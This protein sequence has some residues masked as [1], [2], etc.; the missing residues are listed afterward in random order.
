MESLNWLP[1]L[2]IMDL[3]A[4]RIQNDKNLLPSL[5]KTKSMFK[6]KCWWNPMEDDL[7]QTVEKVAIRCSNCR[8][9]I[10]ID[11]YIMDTIY[12]DIISNFVLNTMLHHFGMLYIIKNN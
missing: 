4:Y 6:I 10:V 2:D 3:T 11:V 7:K 9:E 8:K 5:L 12:Q 1:F